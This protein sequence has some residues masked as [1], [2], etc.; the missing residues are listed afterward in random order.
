M[1]VR[2]SAHASLRMLELGLSR[3]DVIQIVDSP[4]V[5][6]RGPTAIEAEKLLDRQL[7]RVVYTEKDEFILLITVHP[8]EAS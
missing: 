5:E 6:T 8:I 1:D 3:E 2:F 7:W 4:D